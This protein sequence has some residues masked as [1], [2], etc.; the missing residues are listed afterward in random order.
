MM[1]GILDQFR[2]ANARF[3]LGL[4]DRMVDVYMCN[5]KSF[6]IQY[7]ANEEPKKE[8]YRDEYDRYREK[9]YRMDSGETRKM[10]FNIIKFFRSADYQIEDN[11]CSMEAGMIFWDC[12]SVLVSN[13][14]RSMAND[15]T[16]GEFDV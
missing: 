6:N 11:E 8:E 4:Y 16:W 13:V 3:K 7:Y 2:E 5:V 12:T 10:F 15:M 14:F 1:H 9:G